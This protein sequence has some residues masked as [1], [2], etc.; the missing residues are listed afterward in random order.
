MTRTSRGAAAADAVVQYLTSIGVDVAFGIPGVHNLELFRALDDSGI[1]TIVTRHEQAAAYAADGYARATGRL[2]VCIST[3]GPGVANTAAAMGEA[4]ASRSPVLHIAT[5]VDS[6]TLAGKSGRGVLHKSPDQL[7]LMASVCVSATRARTAAELLPAVVRSVRAALAGRR[8]P[9]FVEAA[10]DLFS[11]PAGPPSRRPSHDL[12]P[13]RPGDD[14]IAKAV[15]LLD[16]CRRPVVWAGGGV[17]ASAASDELVRLAEVIDAP[18]ITTFAAKGVI[19]PAHPLAV[20]LPPHQPEVTDLIARADG[21]VVAGSD[22]D[23]HSTQGWRLRLPHPRVAVNVVAEDARRNYAADVVIEA[24]AK[25]ALGALGEMCKPRTSASA[26]GRVAALRA[27]ALSALRADR[28]T[29]EPLRFVER[30]GR[31]LPADAMVVGD[32]TIPGYWSAAYLPVQQP[33]GFA[34]PLGWGTL[35]FAFPAALGVAASGRRA[36]VIAGDGGFLF[37]AGELATAVQE[38]LDI[39]IV[40]VNDGGYGMLRY[41]EDE[42][43]GERFAVDLATPDFVALAKAFGAHARAATPA[44]IG[45]AVAWSLGRRGPSLI[46]VEAAWDPPLTTSPRWPLKG[47]PEARP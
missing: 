39:T 1:R 29:A 22:L 2:G 21:I 32:M 19:P 31:A 40:L 9:A 23:G 7:Q 24:D 16:G 36:V 5:Q 3:T 26:A 47:K 13:K 43:F 44:Q 45:D 18:V 42:R 10:Y 25:A 27:A 33:R 6:R 30:L 14:A 34:F 41:D 12:R 46:E 28:R 8:G 17:A 37:A 4:R 35:G 15:H 38:R 11:Q 20:G